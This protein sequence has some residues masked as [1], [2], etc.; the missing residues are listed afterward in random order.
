MKTAAFYRKLADRSCTTTREA[1]Q[2][3]GLRVP[4][5]SM[6]L[7]RLAAEGLVIPVKRGHWLVGPAAP[8]AG[9][10][11][12]VAAD[13]YRAY[14]SGWSALRVHGRIQQIPRKHFAVTLGRPREV[15]LG[16][17]GVSLHHVA[18]EVFGGYD[19]DSRGDGFVASAEK[20]IFDMAYLAAMNRSRVGAHLPETDLRG[21]RWSEVKAWVARIPAQSMRPVV[22]RN[23]QRIREE[24]ASATGATLPDE[25]RDL[26]YIP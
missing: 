15:A 18:P 7:R 24:R 23:L 2:L 26:N 20:A 10:L 16:G 25:T 8:R 6:K 9:A 5:A 1:A 12:A 3:T 22:L 4:A 14:L 11:V 17:T 13:P 21:L 19:Y